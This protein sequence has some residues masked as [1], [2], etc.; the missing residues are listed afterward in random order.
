MVL[1]RPSRSKM[2][3]AGNSSL[4]KGMYYDR[5]PSSLSIRI[6][7]L[8][9]GKLIDGAMSGKTASCLQTSLENTEDQKGNM[10]WAELKNAEEDVFTAT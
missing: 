2:V 3:A 6:D 10:F 5:T 9:S 4:I 7:E 1:L 8:W